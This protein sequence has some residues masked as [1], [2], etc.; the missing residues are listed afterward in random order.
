MEQQEPLPRSATHAAGFQRPGALSAPASCPGLLSLQR[1]SPDSRVRSPALLSLALTASAAERASFTKLAT[2]D[3]DVLFVCESGCC[4]GDDAAALR[5]RRDDG[6]EQELLYLLPSSSAL[7][8]LGLPSAAP[9]FFAVSKSTLFP[10]PDAPS[11]AAASPL[12]EEPAAVRV[13]MAAVE[14]H[15][16]MAQRWLPVAYLVRELPPPSSLGSFAEEDPEAFVKALVYGSFKQ[17]VRCVSGWLSPVFTSIDGS[18][19]LPFSPL[20]PN[21]TPPEHRTTLSAPPLKQPA[22]AA[23]THWRS[24]SRSRSRDREQQHGCDRGRSRSRRGRSP[25]A[26]P[27]FARGR[28]PEYDRDRRRYA[29]PRPPPAVVALPAELEAMLLSESADDAAVIRAAGLPAAWCCLHTHP[30][31]VARMLRFAEDV[32]RRQPPCKWPPSGEELMAHAVRFTFGGTNERWDT[33]RTRAVELMSLAGRVMVYSD[34]N[35][36]RPDVAI[37]LYASAAE[38][39]AALELSSSRGGWKYWKGERTVGAL[40]SSKL[41]LTHVGMMPYIPEGVTADELQPYGMRYVRLAMHTGS[42]IPA[43]RPGP[44]QPLAATASPAAAMQ[45]PEPPAWLD[46]QLPRSP[47]DASHIQS[48]C[49]DAA[50]LHR[51]SRSR[52]RERTLSPAA[53]PRHP[54]PAAP[55]PA[56]LEAMLL[57]ESEDDAAV[58]R[59]AGLP[60]AWCCLHTQ[61]REVAR[62]LLFA[63]DVRRRHLPCAR[64]NGREALLACT[65]AARLGRSISGSLTAQRLSSCC[66]SLVGC[67]SSTTPTLPILTSGRAPTSL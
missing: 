56:E 51:R 11:A 48:A 53:A 35:E 29:M 5:A 44:M 2:T 57:S 25:E 52:E 33:D 23:A 21:F 30:R 46:E 12:S 26:R 18:E 4:E 64:L 67:S 62:M 6:H 66:R 41:P 32:R 15:L 37:V 24:R 8:R 55:L 19:L 14:K 49:P 16:A 50:Q 7:R 47:E 45:L 54:S 22:A 61:P 36:R 31:E 38:A 60:A 58:I 20:P 39:V 59:A 3:E 28:S 9:S 13:Y 43:R 27:R 17:H 1:L 63:E 65:S 40:A 34:S 10:T 42:L